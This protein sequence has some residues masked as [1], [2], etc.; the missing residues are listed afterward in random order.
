ERQLEAIDA[1]AGVVL[2]ASRRDIVDE[3]GAI[4]FRRR[5]LGRLSG[6]VP[7][8]QALRAVVRAGTNPFG[9]PAAVLFRTSAF[10]SAG[11]FRAD[12]P[13]VIDI[14]MWCRILQGGDLYACRETLCAF[15]LRSGSWSH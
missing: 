2:V 10:R 1:D 3:A 6:K 4:V 7:G 5:G 9:E 8:P 15:R 12:L 14:D 13:Y 11:P